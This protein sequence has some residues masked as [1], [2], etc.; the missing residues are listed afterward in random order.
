[1]LAVTDRNAPQCLK[2]ALALHG[3][4][5]LSLP[6]HP[7][8]PAPIAGHPDLL[9]FFLPDAILTTE[10]YSEIARRELE[11]LGKHTGKPIVTVAEELSETY[12]GDVLFNAAP[13]GTRLFCHAA[14]CS[15]ALTESGAFEICPV[16][17]GYAKC[18]T[19][20]VGDSALITADASIEKA[21]HG[22]G[23]DVLRVSAGF[24]SL[25]GYDTG[26]LGGASS[27]APYGGVDT[28]Y[29]C[30]SLDSHPDAGAIRAFCASHGTVAAS[31]DD[32][33]PL[34]DI[35]TVFLL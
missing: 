8:L 24:V 34:S 20:P 16:K 2:N 7:A 3:F 27:F 11:V 31:L 14:G 30:G 9:L 5:L 6:P 13:V 1:M 26:F 23:L 15:R 28:V 17:Q 29:F 21:A 4:S 32:S 10:A 18:S 12:P 22:A 33:L 19:V 35:G 25:T